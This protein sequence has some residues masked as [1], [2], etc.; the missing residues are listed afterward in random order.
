MKYL[1]QIM[2][3]GGITFAG[4]MLH[5]LIPLPVPASV[6]GM[7]I[8]FICLCL[9]AIKEEQI[10]DTAQ[11]LLAIMP[12]MFIGPGVEIMEHYTKIADSLIPFAVVVLIS[13]V[14]VMA[15]T[16]LTVQGVMAL[17]KK[18]KKGEKRDA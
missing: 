4:E 6:Y 12:V 5:V 11:W 15:A 17:K 14:L 1:M 13:T 16:G 9:G 8:L 18:G 10:E 3:I 2:I 7:V